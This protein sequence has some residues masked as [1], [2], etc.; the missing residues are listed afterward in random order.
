[1]TVKRDA[2]GEHKCAT[3]PFWHN[4]KGLK[5]GLCIAEAPQ[6]IYLGMMPV[7]PSALVKPDRPP[8]MLPRTLSAVPE[9]SG[10]FGC[11]RHP[12]RFNN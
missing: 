6:V 10:D 2:I 4:P 1:M 12:S 9:T 11:A 3:C 7:A 8:E 5:I